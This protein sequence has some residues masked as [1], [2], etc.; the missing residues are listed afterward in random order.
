LK[1]L[2]TDLRDRIQRIVELSSEAGFRITRLEHK[3]CV[4]EMPNTG[5]LF[6]SWNLVAEKA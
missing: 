4:D 5:Q 2:A 6:A 3:Q 1:L